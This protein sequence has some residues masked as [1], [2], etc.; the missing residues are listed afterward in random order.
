MGFLGFDIDIPNPLDGAGS[1][2]DKVHMP[3]G[4]VMRNLGQV[5]S[6]ATF[7]LFDSDK[8]D[9][10][11]DDLYNSA[12][13]EATSLLQEQMDPAAGFGGA[14]AAGAGLPAYGQYDM[15]GQYGGYSPAPAGQSPGPQGPQSTDLNPGVTVV[16]PMTPAVQTPQTMGPGVPVPTGMLSGGAVS[17]TDPTVG[18]GGTQGAGTSVS[19]GVPSGIPDFAQQAGF[20]GIDNQAGDQGWY[21][22]G[23]DGPGL[24]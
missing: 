13:E 10:E 2:L 9:Q 12:V 15:S 14:N 7:G 4:G 1:L 19:Q 5:G 21:A 20:G 16:P 8:S 24:G 11:Q 22:G 18:V 17:M 3:G 23:A 6:D